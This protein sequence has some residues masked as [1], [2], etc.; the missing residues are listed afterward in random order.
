[1][2]ARLAQST[3]LKPRRFLSRLRVAGA[4]LSRARDGSIAVLFAFALLALM[5][6]V[7]ASIDL[8]NAF[9]AR[10]KL[11]QVA[12]LACQYSNRTPIVQNSVSAGSTYTT[13]VN[14]FISTS[15]ARQNFLLTQSNAT[16]F[17]FTS[18][19]AAM[20]SLA[21]SVPTEFMKIARITSVPISVTMTCY[22]TPNVQTQ[23]P[24]G[25]YVLQE[26]FNKTI[27]TWGGNSAF[28]LPNGSLGMPYSY[29]PSAF[30]TTVSYTGSSG[31]KFSKRILV[32]VASGRSKLMSL[33]LS[34]AK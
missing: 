20:V 9:V 4:R 16:P 10:Q 32:L 29:T 1:M 6:V 12:V 30:S 3:R 14:Q 11:S 19:G 22:S 24:A 31:V 13:Q 8:A 15:L 2:L 21:S 33:T 25:S 7:G 23:P 28:Y 17:T 34:S 18:G 26:R 27:T 5:T